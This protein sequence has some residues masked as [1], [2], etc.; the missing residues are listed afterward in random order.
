[1]ERVVT[2]RRG[3]QISLR[4]IGVLET[5]RLYKALGADLSANDSYMGLAMMAAAACVI[6]GVPLPFPI[7]ETAVEAALER[8]GDDGAEA[9][10]AA[11]AADD[12]GKVVVDAGN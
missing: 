8:L 11:M 5:L 6:D 2:D 4:D 12:V 3:R 7:S 10:G 9:V 1:M